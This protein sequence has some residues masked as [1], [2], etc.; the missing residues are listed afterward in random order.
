MAKFLIVYLSER[1]TRLMRQI[2]S[3]VELGISFQFIGLLLFIV[4]EWRNGRDLEM[5]PKYGNF[6]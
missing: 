3:H 1:K 4:N 2:S 6:R 5:Y